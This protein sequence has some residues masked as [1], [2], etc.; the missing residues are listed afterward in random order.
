[1]AENVNIQVHRNLVPKVSKLFLISSLKRT[2]SKVGW[3]KLLYWK[4][5]KIRPMLYLQIIIVYKTRKH[6]EYLN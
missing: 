5:N 3:R 4:P 2:K 1:M 6:D